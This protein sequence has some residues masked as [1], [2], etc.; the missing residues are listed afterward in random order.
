MLGGTLLQTL[1]LFLMTYRT[2]WNTEVT[3]TLSMS[4]ARKTKG[5]MSD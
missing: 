1:V 2:N 4:S 5:H 3:I